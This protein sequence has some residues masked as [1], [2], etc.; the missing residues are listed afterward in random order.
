MSR[1]DAVLAAIILV[2]G[3]DMATVLYR[4]G[5]ASARR[6]WIVVAGWLVVLSLAGAAFLGFG[7][8]L[9]TSF[10]IPGTPT[11]KV[12]DAISTSLPALTGTSATVVFQSDNGAFTDAQKTAIADL[13]TK[14]GKSEGVVSTTDP[15]ATQA[16]RV[17]QSD[18]LNAASQQLT[19]ARTQITGGL[20]KLSTG[21][22]QLDAAIA[23]A[24]AAGGYAALAS[25][26]SQQQA[27]I[28]AQ[29]SA[30]QTK[31]SELDAQQAQV[32]DG[33]ALLAMAA[34]LRTI[35]TDGS[36]AL[37]V[38]AFGQSQFSLPQTQKDAVRAELAS[39][40]IP[41]V[42]VT[43][44]ATIADELGGLGGKE[45]LGVLIAA[46]VLIVMMRALL[47]AVTPLISSVIGVGVGVAACMAFSGKVSM[48]SVTPMLG[49]M[50]GLAVGIDYSLFIL[51]RHRKQLLAGAQVHESIGLATGTA[52]N[53]VVFAG[54]TVV[55]ALLALNVTRI[56]F[57]G[58]MGDVAAVCVAVA[59][60]VAVTFTP[61]LLGLF[62]M[63]VLG[64]RDRARIGNAPSVHDVK[65]MPTLRAVLS[66]VLGAAILLV[67]AIPALSM[68]LGLPDG[69]QEPQDS[70]QYQAFHTV[71][72][73]FGA[74]VNGP[75]LVVATLPHA[76]SSDDELATQ[77]AIATQLHKQDDVVAVAPAA[78]S[79]S[80]TVF[81]F[82]VVPEDGP[83]SVSTE[84]LVNHLRSMSP[85][86]LASTGDNVTLGVAG[87][88][89]G[90]IDVSQ[91]LADALPLYLV[92]VIGLSLII[93][94]V[95]F[96]SLL[97][98]LIAT[99]GYVLSLFAAL[100]AMTA[101]Y[102]WG[103]LGTVFGVHDPGPLLS[104]API[105]LMGVLFGLAMDY[106][107]F[108][109]SGMREAYVHGAD[110]R[111]AVM[112]GMWHG[113]AV[114]TAAAIIMIAV[115]GGF[116]FSQ[117][118]T[119]RPLG[120]GLAVGVLFDAFVVR[121][122]LMPGLMHLV[123]RGAWWLPGWLDRLLPNVDVEGASIER[124]HPLMAASGGSPS[125]TA[126]KRAQE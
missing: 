10:S 11:Q 98:P 24:K 78:V 15:F 111:T 93:L 100:G 82:E 22:S 118:T 76:V 32:S 115:F 36:T 63:H 64:R 113:R 35:S 119:V 45:L 12:T 14:V 122:V 43:W 96:R 73:K 23:Q 126:P 19:A 75:L 85:I 56:P 25:Q 94:V 57:L 66:V 5:L 84:Q 80:R 41:G 54:S 34:K 81:A 13:L 18:K 59:V 125:S 99:G 77:V 50:L 46:V 61:A 68:R 27:Q 51:N 8:H 109:V 87:Q 9:A 112:R 4:L 60:L 97:V 103:W 106:Q 49:L 102:Q 89:S 90:N 29:R 1:P 6:A 120:F 33:Q 79:D 71:A 3:M 62:G 67:L 121:L 7:G 110:A 88:S 39:A 91:K 52:G 105:L 108:L 38:V 20:G 65:P 53:A 86:A 123:G 28:D 21:Q 117:S 55:I 42:K 17:A 37:G 69:S 70:A 16:Q 116:I 104:F 26:F 92:V 114:V 48:S 2:K 44:S 74:G 83:S 40:D 72:D 58:V 31:S 101:V 107:L 124:S 95:V 30:L 47:P